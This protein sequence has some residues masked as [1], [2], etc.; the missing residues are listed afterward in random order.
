[1]NWL[2]LW[3]SGRLPTFLPF[4]SG[5]T[6]KSRALFLSRDPE[7]IGYGLAIG[8]AD[9]NFHFS[10]QEF[11]FSKFRNLQLIDQEGSVSADKSLW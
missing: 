7:L 5:G 11:L 1:M 10:N 2:P 9:R 4:L 8:T 3:A 6:A